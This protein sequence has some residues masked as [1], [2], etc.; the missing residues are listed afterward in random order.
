[1]KEHRPDLSGHLGLKSPE[2]PYLQPLPPPLSVAPGAWFQFV[3][4]PSV[5]AWAMLE[6]RS[7]PAQP[8]LCPSIGP[9]DLDPNLKTDFLA[10]PQPCALSWRTCLRIWT[11]GWNWPPT[12]SR[13]ALPCPSYLCTVGMGF[14]W[15]EPCLW[16][17]Y[18]ICLPIPRE[19]PALAVPWCDFQ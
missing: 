12:N 4:Q 18:V 10:R 3:L 2:Q 6:G 8:Q 11:L 19:Q 14:G 5:P 1:M 15:Q 13:S 9:L 17:E 7:S 16:A